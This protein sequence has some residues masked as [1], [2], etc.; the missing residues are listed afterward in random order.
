MTSQYP[1]HIEIFTENMT[2]VNRLLD[3]HS[4][5]TGTGVGRRHNVQIL[6]KSAVLI[7]VATWESYMEDLALVTTECLTHGVT[8]PDLL[9]EELKKTTAKR[10]EKEKHDNE[11]WLL[12]GDGW[13][14]AV[15][16]STVKLVERLNTPSAANIDR[17]F[18]STVGFKNLSRQWTWKGS[19]NQSVLD[20][21]DRLLTIRHEVSHQVHSARSINKAYVQKSTQLVARISAVSTNRMRTHVRKVTGIVPW[22]RFKY[23]AT[24]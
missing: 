8:T 9:P 15:S 13:K 21:L 2:E 24:V 11:V 5:L 6:N 16:S 22:Q 3:I 1:P 4:E 14:D 17:L 18:Q 10:L 7:L 20:R 12:A 19:S 23:G